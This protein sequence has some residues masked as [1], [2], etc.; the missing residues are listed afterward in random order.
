[1]I[2]NKQTEEMV[3]LRLMR[4]LDAR[5]ILYE[6]GFLTESQYRSIRLKIYKEADEWGIEYRRLCADDDSE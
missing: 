4:C 5:S 6:Q 2:L 1:M 3:R